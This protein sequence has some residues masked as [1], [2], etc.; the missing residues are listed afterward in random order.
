MSDDVRHQTAQDDAELAKITQSLRRALEQRAHFELEVLNARDHAIVQSAQ[1]GELRHRLIK[2][3]A[4]LEQRRNDYLIHS[5][6]Y[7]AHIARLE[8]ALA[9]ATRKAAVAESLRRELAAS[10]ES[11]TWKAGRIVMLPVR[12]MK[13][14]LRRT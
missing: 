8:A 5:E 9:D 7:L 4:L 10:R 3:A 14:L 13:R 6:N 2:Q 1:I 11:T 12:A